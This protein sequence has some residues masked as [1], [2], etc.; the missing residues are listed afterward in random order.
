MEAH[1]IRG[2]FEYI[3]TF[4]LGLF[5][6]VEMIEVKFLALMFWF[7]QI[8]VLFMDLMSLCLRILRSFLNGWKFH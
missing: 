5:P 6:I 1:N 8:Q 2:K 7:F 4:P 3:C